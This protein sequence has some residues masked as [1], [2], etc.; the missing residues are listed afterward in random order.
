M[1]QMFQTAVDKGAKKNP[2]KS[3]ESSGINTHI[4][5]SKTKP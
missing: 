1:V 2:P 4:V 5:K 3:R